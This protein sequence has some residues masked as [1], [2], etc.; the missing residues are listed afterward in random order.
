MMILANGASSGKLLIGGDVE[1]AQVDSVV[2]DSHGVSTFLTHQS[3]FPQG[4][5]CARTPQTAAMA[6]L[7]LSRG[8]LRLTE[9]KKAQRPWWRLKQMKR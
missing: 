1:K 8:P 5:S 4:L 3:T 9:Q 6:N 2:E 7:E